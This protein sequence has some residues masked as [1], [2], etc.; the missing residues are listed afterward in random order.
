MIGSIYENDPLVGLYTLPLLVWYPL[1][2]VVGSFLIP[3]LQEFVK[4]EEQRLEREDI[5][6]DGDDLTLEGD[7]LNE[8]SS[9]PSK[10][11][12][13]E[14]KLL[15]AKEIVRKR[16]ENLDL[17]VGAGIFRCDTDTSEFGS[18]EDLPDKENQ[19]FDHQQD[20]RSRAPG[21][22]TGDEAPPSKPIH[23]S[24][25]NFMTC[26]HVESADGVPNLQSQCFRDKQDVE[27]STK[28]QSTSDTS[29]ET[30]VS[31]NY[32]Q[33]REGSNH[34]K[35]DGDT[36]ESFKSRRKSRKSSRSS[37][38]S[39]SKKKRSRSQAECISDHSFYQV[40]AVYYEETV[41]RRVPEGSYCRGGCS[42][43][44][45]THFNEIGILPSESSPVYICRRCQRHVVCYVCWNYAKT[46]QWPNDSLWNLY[47]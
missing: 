46:P 31:K 39:G 20:E 44:I 35:T 32:G 7:S 28:T 16:Y 34:S 9:G 19:I 38:S 25:R 13:A 26:T 42:T 40:E 4:R 37:K 8:S 14:P 33:P 11:D 6:D 24:S 3:R 45:A 17:E 15:N 10:G 41:P 43:R 36:V 2:L 1:Q 18:E 27:H 30:D 29:V 5:G 22:D 21:P 47:G 12:K 23:S